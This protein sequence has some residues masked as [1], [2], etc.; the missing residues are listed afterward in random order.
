MRGQEEETARFAPGDR[1]EMILSP[2]TAVAEAKSLEARGFLVLGGEQRAMEAK[3]HVEPSGVVKLEGSIPRD[4][5][6]GTWTLWAVVGRPGEL[7]DPAELQSL[8]AQGETRQ[9]NWVAVSQD[10]RIQPRGP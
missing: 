7:P 2:D 8:A 4:L 1:Y 3:I 9:R 10:V 5:Q 6:T